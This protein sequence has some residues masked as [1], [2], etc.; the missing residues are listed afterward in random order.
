MRAQLI[1]LFCIASQE[2]VKVCFI[3]CDA[4]VDALAMNL[5]D[6]APGVCILPRRSGRGGFIPDPHGA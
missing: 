6:Q 4:V 5:T 1:V 3:V 2:P